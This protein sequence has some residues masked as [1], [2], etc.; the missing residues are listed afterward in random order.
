MPDTSSMFAERVSQRVSISMWKSIGR[1]PR[2]MDSL[3]PMCSASV[4]S[5]IGGQ[6]SLKIS[7]AANAIPIKVRY[8][9]DFRD[10]T[11]AIEARAL[12]ATPAGAQIPISKWRGSTFSRGPAMIRDEDGPL[13][14]YVYLDLK[15]RTMADS[16]TGRT[17]SSTRN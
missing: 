14:G 10:N 6:T 7:K 4:T 16:L 17:G 5:E 3:W 12:I 9:R 8:E 13:T 11:E 2:V 15:R 1:K